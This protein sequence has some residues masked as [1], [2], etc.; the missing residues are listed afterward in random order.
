VSIEARIIVMLLTELAK[1]ELATDAIPRL[2]V[3]RLK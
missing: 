1:K 2:P 3:T